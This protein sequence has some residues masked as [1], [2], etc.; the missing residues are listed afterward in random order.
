MYYSSEELPIDWD[1]CVNVE[2]AKFGGDLLVSDIRQ[3]VKTPKHHLKCID[4]K[5]SNASKELTN[6]ITLIANGTRALEDFKLE[7]RVPALGAFD[8][9]VEMN[10]SL[11]YVNIY[12][13][14]VLPNAKAIH[15]LETFL[16]APGLK[17]IALRH[18]GGWT[19]VAEPIPEIERICRQN[20]Y[21][22]LCVS[23]LG[24]PYLR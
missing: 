1:A 10:K 6:V 2:R 16:K 19:T 7:C 15:T 17:N 22:R 23:V 5:V 13:H 20:R 9:L 8:K 24:V 4:I 14:S 11:S 3:L 18:L 21:R 12:F